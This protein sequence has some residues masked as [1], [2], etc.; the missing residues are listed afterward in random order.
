MLLVATAYFQ[1]T[2]R[3]SARLQHPNRPSPSASC[4]S[5]RHERPGGERVLVGPSD[6][7]LAGA[8]LA[9]AR[10]ARLDR[11]VGPAH[12]VHIVGLPRN[13]SFEVARLSV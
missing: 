2:T 10:L 9:V 8:V 3:P 1:T 7:W 13:L 11:Y 6:N 12:A 4:Q 5:F